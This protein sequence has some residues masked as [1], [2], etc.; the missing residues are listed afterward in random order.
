MNP[1]THAVRLGLLRGWIEF[2]QSL[3]NVGD[4]VYYVLLAAVFLA[5]LFFQRNST[6]EGTDLSLAT[7]VMPSLL[8]G[9][10]AFQ[11][12]GGAAY[13]LAAEREDGTLLRA[14]TIPQ[15]IIGYLSGRVLGLS[16]GTLPLLI[17]ILI[18]SLLLV[19]GLAS[20][21]ASRWLTLVWVFVLGLLATL[22]LGMIVG[23]LVKGP[24]AANTWGIF[25]T[26]ALVG[27]SGILYPIQS[28][29]VW[30]QN[31]AQVFPVYW[32]GLG[33]RSVFLPDAA[34]AVEI[35]GSWRHLE[36]AGVLTAW[37]IVGLLL[38]PIVLRR[39]ARRES[40]SKV[41][42]RQQEAMKRIG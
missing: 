7:V 23:S 11:A 16:M 41:Q 17:L 26:M 20:L 36:T 13:S 42:D 29:P 4:V 30:V 24:R 35:T 8:G 6:V 32:L 22:P 27:I 18:P 10:L 33:T 1:T 28:L 19:D 21:D 2:R 38:A 37:A 5:V 9:L 39:S 31:I 3:T 15:G 12:M 40:G 34:A 14:K 25:P